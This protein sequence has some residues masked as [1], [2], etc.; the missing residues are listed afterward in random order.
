MMNRSNLK[1]PPRIGYWIFNYMPKWEAASKEVSTLAAY[2]HSDFGTRTISLN[3]RSDKLA[4][5]GR[6]MHLPLPYALIALPFL[7]HTAKALEI[8]HV[9]AS[10]TE[11]LLTP[12]LARLGNAILTISKDNPHLDELERNIGTL[13]SL[14]YIVVESKRH[15]DLLMQVGVEPERVKLIYPGVARQPYH[16]PPHR[17]FTILFASSPLANRYDMLSRGIYL[18]VRAATHLP[19][20]KFRVIWRGEEPAKLRQLISDADASNVEVISGYVEDM[21]SMYDTAHAVIL[22]ALM[23]TSLK[24]CPHSGLE[25]LAHGKPV[26]VSRPTSISDIVEREGCGVTFEPNIASLCDSIA[27]LRQS[28]GGYQERAQPTAARMFSREIF[29]DYYRQL[30]LSLLDERP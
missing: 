22:P 15:R 2:F 25:S 11:R 16:Q 20:T 5:S 28:Y 10:P 24:P 8:N 1:V 21:K 26:L 30:Y 12:R 27:R 7:K 14:H 3:L 6:N 9:F 29:V 13:R 18:M 17:P 4:F 23:E 19:D